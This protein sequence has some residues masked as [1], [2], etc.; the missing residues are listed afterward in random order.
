MRNLQNVFFLSLLGLS[1]STGCTVT[2]SDGPLDEEGG[3][4]NDTTAPQAGSGGSTTAVASGGTTATS[5]TAVGTAGTTNV[6]SGGTT[7]ATTASTPAYTVA[8]CPAFA[9][10]GAP[11]FAA[12]VSAACVSCI[13]D[14]NKACT[15]AIACQNESDCITR[16]WAA[17]ECIEFRFQFGGAIAISYT[18]MRHCQNGA[19][20]GTAKPAGAEQLTMKA[21]GNFW[22]GA[23]VSLTGGDLL[24]TIT[25][26]CAAE[27]DATSVP[28]P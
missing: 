12:D 16:V 1:L 28:D 7:A 6:A 14:A 20:I 15:Q 13:Y 24:T 8:N 18:E 19:S 26:S 9:T 22:E 21:T 27:C 5:T 4:G 2:T 10:A 17:L 23:D 11:A 25:T 3:T